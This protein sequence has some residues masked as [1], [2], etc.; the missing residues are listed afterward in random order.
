[1]DAKGIDIIMFKN[2]YH[3]SVEERLTVSFR[4]DNDRSNLKT[5]H[6]SLV[7]ERVVDHLT[8]FPYLAGFNPTN[9][10]AVRESIF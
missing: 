9:F 4:I 7:N 2:D 6:L 10:I 8:C 5:V 3:R 1:M